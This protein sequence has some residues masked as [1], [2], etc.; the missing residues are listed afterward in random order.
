M[1][2]TTLL[3]TVLAAGS[4]LLGNSAFA[5]GKDITVTDYLPGPYRQTPSGED[6]EVEPNNQQHQTWD[7]ERLVA[8]AVSS[9]S[10]TVI[11]GYDFLNGAKDPGANRYY[12]T[13]DIWID[14]NPGNLSAGT[15]SGGGYDL[16]STPHS[17]LGYDFVLHFG[18]R[19]AASDP[20]NPFKLN[21]LTYQ[22][23][24]LRGSAA[25]GYY[26]VFF[27]QN[28]AS[29]PFVYDSGGIALALGAGTA[30]YANIGDSTAT[31]TL[32]GTTLGVTDWEDVT[33]WTPTG[34]YGADVHYRL[35]V[36]LAAITNILGVNLDEAKFTF[37]CGNDMIVGDYNKGNIRLPDGGTTLAMLGFAIIG[38]ALARRRS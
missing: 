18:D 1:K 21:S 4:I 26:D 11:G 9:K 8:G 15:G 13:G 27:A 22:I 37:G 3:A 7:L 10:L 19:V 12:H 34:T 30:G 20:V 24:D 28:N 2:N 32:F 5:A 16:L 6:N 36:D 23:Y 31:N 35:D 14:V 33:P 25:V 29:N 17:S 38:M